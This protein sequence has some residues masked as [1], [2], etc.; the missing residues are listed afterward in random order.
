[1]DKVSSYLKTG[2]SN[3][4]YT[5]FIEKVREKVAA[6]RNDVKKSSIGDD[7]ADT[8][9]R[10]IGLLRKALTNNWLIKYLSKDYGWNLQKTEDGSSRTTVTTVDDADTGVPGEDNFGRYPNTKQ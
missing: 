4:I 8:I 2:G 10:R 7:R 9:S 1:M 3:Q 5:R 6:I